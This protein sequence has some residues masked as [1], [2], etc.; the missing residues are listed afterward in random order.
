MV[1][2]RSTEEVATALGLGKN[3]VYIAKNR[4]LTRLRQ[5]IDGLLD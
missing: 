5:V 4:V 1:H 2:N 3:A